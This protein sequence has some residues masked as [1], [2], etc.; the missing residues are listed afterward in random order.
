M[1]A[2][3][4]EQTITKCR[5]RLDTAL[6]R[7]LD[8]TLTKDEYD[9]AR[10]RYGIE[11]EAASSE[12]A[13]LRELDAPPAVPPLDEVL[14]D[15]NSWCEIMTGSDIAAQR[16]ML[17]LLVERVVP[18]RVGRGEYQAQIFWTPLGGALGQLK[19]DTAAA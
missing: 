17:A 11:M 18:T 13:K 10:T 15:A 5:T 8:G 3:A 19:N 7:V 12:L 16:D 9:R 4:L 2:Q 6:D 14:R 1:Q